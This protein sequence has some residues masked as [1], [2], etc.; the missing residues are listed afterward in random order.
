MT[1]KHDQPKRQITESQLWLTKNK[2]IQRLADQMKTTIYQKHWPKKRANFENLHKPLLII[3]LQNIWRENQ[4]AFQLFCNLDKPESAWMLARIAST[5]IHRKAT[6]VSLFW[7]KTINP[8]FDN[9]FSPTIFNLENIAFVRLVFH[10]RSLSDAFA[11][12]RICLCS[13][14]WFCFWPCA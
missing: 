2:L 13:C 4:L 9:I 11:Q 6:N 5:A 8:I 1:K 12:C 10:D 7:W 3:G 14:I